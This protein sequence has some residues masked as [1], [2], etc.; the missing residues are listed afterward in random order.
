MPSVLLYSGARMFRA[1]LKAHLDQLQVGVVGRAASMRAFTLGGGAAGLVRVDGASTG[2]F[3][4]SG[5]ANGGL[6][7]SGDSSA[8][9]VLSGSA[10]GSVT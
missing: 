9:V 1:T 7:V 6:L 3:D 2:S 5:A 4:L 10:A 8:V